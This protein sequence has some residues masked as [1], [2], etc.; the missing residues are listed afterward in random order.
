MNQTT[1]GRL[2]A[3]DRLTAKMLR[4]APWLAFPAV[5]LPAPLY[6]LWRY[7]TSAEDFAVWMLAAL[8]AFGVSALLALGVV[9]LIVLYRRHWERR[10]RDRLAANG[11]TAD[12]LDWFRAELTRAERRTL[13]EMQQRSPL[14]ADA[15]RDTLAARLTATRVAA[16]AGRERVAVERRL[17]DAAALLGPDR[18]RLEAD[19]R[20][21]RERLERIAREAE[22]H[23]AEAEA[24]L[25][26][27]EAAAGRNL[28]EDETARALA[29]LDIN[30]GQLPFALEAAR[31]EQ[32]AREEIDRLLRAGSASRSQTEREP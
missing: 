17:Q 8:T 20:A 25:H 26:M 11:V 24:R 27:I 21:D 1:D 18:A 29:R 28:S 2:T 4:L 22:E 31:E 23:R 5:A 32:Q 16:H 14:L 13:R 10:L 30:K 3:S 7:F 6:F 9:V 19:L 12:E 15:Y